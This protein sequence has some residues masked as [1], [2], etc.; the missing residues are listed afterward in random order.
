MDPVGWIAAWLEW[1]TTYY[2]A[3]VDTPHGKML[4]KD[5]VRR[6]IDGSLFFKIADDIK[7]GKLRRTSMF[8]AGLSPRTKDVVS[9]AAKA[10]REKAD[11]AMKKADVALKSVREKAVEAM[12]VQSRRK[13]L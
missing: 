6:V 13:E 12:P 5:D 3:A 9:P 4:L 8:S 2:V 10:V 7:S 11:M 1:N